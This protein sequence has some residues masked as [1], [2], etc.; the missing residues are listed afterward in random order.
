LFVPEA[1]MSRVLYLMQVDWR[2]IKQ[3]PHILAEGLNT[4][5]NVLVAYRMNLDR[6]RWPEHPSP[7]RRVPLL[8]LLD[9]GGWWFRESDAWL[10][11]LRLAGLIRDFQ[12]DLIWVCFPSLYA[13]L[14]GTARNLPIVYDCMDDPSGFYPNPGDRAYI[15]HL[16]HELIERAKVVLYSS[17]RLL[18]RVQA[19]HPNAPLHLVR[20]GL[21]DTWFG[22]SKPA[23]QPK[24]TDAFE[25]AYIGTIAEWFD[26]QALE[27]ALARIPKLVIH[28]VGPG[29]QRLKHERIVYHGSVAHDQ[30]PTLAAR[31]R[32]FIMPFKLNELIL[33]VDP[34]KL[35]E[36][37]FFGGEVIAVR[38]PE[39][40]RFAPLTHLY[41]DTNEFVM[42]LE[43]LCNGR[44]ELRNAEPERTRAFLRDN[45]WN[46]RV[47]TVLG[48]LAQIT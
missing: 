31:F 12:P 47:Q 18:E 40:E 20:N 41:H 19:Q 4:Q 37:L 38:Y 7:I 39:I 17:T 8:P 48:L 46:Q 24:V 6:G 35:Y 3:R 9:R 13:Y 45:T 33:G 27:V 23:R 11:R 16:E 32:A 44:L 43:Q 25:V 36:Y 34:V 2:W 5:H 22:T 29:P 26:W 15:N 21:K 30:L 10:Q 28:L 42:L 14:P 1:G